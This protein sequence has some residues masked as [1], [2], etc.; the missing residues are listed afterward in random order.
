MKSFTVIVRARTSMHE[1]RALVLAARIGVRNRYAYVSI[2]AYSVLVK[3]YS[4]VG[5]CLRG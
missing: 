4:N 1:S 5:L 2:P 3:N